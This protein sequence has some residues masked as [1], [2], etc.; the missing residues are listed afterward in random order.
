MGLELGQT[1]GQQCPGKNVTGQSPTVKEDFIQSCCNRTERRDPSLNSML[2]KQ[3]AGGVLG[4][5]GAERKVIED[6]TSE[7]DQ[8]D[9]LTHYLLIL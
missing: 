1:W 7:V 3:R 6:I 5:E 9:V 4:V 8:W 2:L